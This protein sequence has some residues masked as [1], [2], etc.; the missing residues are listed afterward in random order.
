MSS[1]KTR[2]KLPAKA[3]NQVK[4]KIEITGRRSGKVSGAPASKAARDRKTAQS[5]TDGSKQALLV[6]RLCGPK[7]A[8]V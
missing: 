2:Q 3:K 5:G 6:E 1:S 8:M 4:P 7:G